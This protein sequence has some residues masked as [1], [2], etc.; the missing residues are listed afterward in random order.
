MFLA[1]LSVA[2]LILFYFSHLVF[3][4]PG[5][6]VDWQIRLCLMFGLLKIDNYKDSAI[7]PNSLDVHL[8]DDFAR[9]R[10]DGTFETFSADSI[11][12]EPGDFVLATTKEFF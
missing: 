12:L 4:A 8:S 7:Q 11:V 2:F 9:Q 1:I 10:S 3:I 5:N 6:L